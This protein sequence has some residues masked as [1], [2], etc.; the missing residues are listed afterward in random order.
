MMTLFIAHLSFIMKHAFHK[1]TIMMR[2]DS[3]NLLI[4]I[5]PGGYLGYYVLGTSMFMKENYDLSRYMFS[6]ASAGA[7]CSL[8]MVMKQTPTSIFDQINN[9]VKSAENLYQTEQQLKK[10][11]LKEYTDEDF[12]LSR[13]YIGVTT[14][15]NYVPKKQIYSNFS[16]LEDA[17]DCC[18][19]SSHIPFIT[20]GILYRYHN[21]ISFD[22]GFSKYP[23]VENVKPK[24]HIHPNIWLSHKPNM[25]LY[26]TTMFSK[27]KNDFKNTYWHGYNDARKNKLFLD[28]LFI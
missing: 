9:H 25:I 8:L 12:D 22:G 24:L 1:K 7:W 27:K 19:A 10:M 4:S 17:I 11:L 28:R 5:S 16:K 2:D 21:A 26:D 15:D 23:Y 3:D 20:G 18:I 14:F 6:G 13:L